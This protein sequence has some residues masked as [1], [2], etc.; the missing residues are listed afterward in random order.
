MGVKTSNVP[1]TAGRDG[2]DMV[3]GTASQQQAATDDVLRL[4]STSRTNVQPV[5][6]MIADRAARICNAQFC[7]VFRFDGELMHFAAHHGLSPEKLAA[8]RRFWPAIP[9]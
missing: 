7:H 3:S 1:V 9:D 2:E 4:I 8:Q 6:D 5:F